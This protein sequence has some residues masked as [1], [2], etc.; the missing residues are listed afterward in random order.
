MILNGR[1]PYKPLDFGGGGVTGSVDADGCLIAL[2]GYHA[3]HGYIT[4]TAAD[5]FPDDQRYDPRAVRAYRASLVH[6]RGFG[7]RA[8]AP[9]TRRTSAL[10]SGALPRLTQHYAD[11]SLH[12]LTFAA[13]GGAYQLWRAEGVVPRWA[14]R[15]NLMRCAYTQL[16]EGGVIAAPPVVQQV[17]LQDGVLTVENPALGAAV[18]VHGF[19]PDQALA[20]TYQGAATLDLALNGAQSGALCYAFG[21]TAQEAANHAVQLAH[22]SPSAHFREA[23]MAW[24][25]RMRD[26]DQN[27]LVQRGLVY[28]LLCAVPVGE[29]VCLLTDHMLLPLSWNRDAYYMARALLAWRGNQSE[30]F[31]VVRRHLIWLFEQAQRL[32]GTHWARCYMANGMVKDP[33]YQLDQQLYPLLEL[34]DYTR[35]SGDQELLARFEGQITAWLQALLARKHAHAALFPT[36]ETPGDDPIALPYHFSSHILLWHTLR[37]LARIGAVGYAWDALANQVRQAI[38]QYFFVDNKDDRRT[39]FHGQSALYAY[40]VDGAGRY[41]LYHDANDLPFALMPFWGF[42]SAADPTWQRTAAFA[43]SPLNNGG[44]Y[45]GRLGSVHTPAAWALGDVQDLLIGQALGD[46]QRQARARA[47]LD[48]A[49]QWDGALS[50]AYDAASG[51]VISRAWFAW[52]NAAL[53]CAELGVFEDDD[54]P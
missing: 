9:I 26:F 53:A 50:E 31:E 33:A 8:D 14:G 19:A 12:I 35:L 4:L 16:T 41:H 38:E 47:F 27:P 17:R 40:A 34:A 6:L 3:Q 2:N 48:A 28:C 13:N 39:D 20:N 45:D 24:A 7:C 1:A 11:G 5:P 54:S 36:D 44:Y 46:D 37:A 32:N 15:F 49:A 52:T 43:F 18:A 30:T 23:G 42:C 10:L 51:A 29:G 25:H 21:E 22:G